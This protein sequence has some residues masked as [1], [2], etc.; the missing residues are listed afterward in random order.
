MSDCNKIYLDYAATTPVDDRVISKMM[1]YFNQKFGNSMG[2]CSFG[3][4]ANKALEDARTTMSKFINGKNG[5][6]IFT[7]SATESNNLALKGVF[8]ANQNQGK[9]EI[10]VS[11]V[12][13]DCV[14]NSAKYL[15]NKGYKLKYAP[16]DEFGIIKLDE[17]KKLITQKTLI[18]SIMH[19][20]NEVGSINPIAEIGKICRQNQALFHTD[21]AQ[22][23]GKENIDVEK[24]GIDMLTTSS[25][26][27]YGPKG[28]AF[29]WVRNGVSIEPIIHGGGQEFGLRS[30]TV[31]VPAIVGFSEATKIAYKEMKKEDIRLKK[32]RDKIFDFILKE[33]PNSKINGHVSKRLANNINASFKGIEGESIM[34][35]LDMNGLSVSTGSA[36]SSNKLEPSHVLVGMGLD[37]KYAQSAIRISL[38][39]FTKSGDVEYLLE[40]LKEVVQNLRKISPF[41]K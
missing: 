30:S 40:T 12:E 41:S 5:R 28:A 4:E 8:G 21:A 14:L 7:S 39:R 13:H 25:H 38:G 33:I 18:V 22:S 10:I 35:L 24:M 32:L 16:V 6:V 9:S 37:P 34:M 1:P 11:K 3:Q 23:F 36:C 15:E 2:I 27:A 29:L 20:N 26:K 19:A 17:L 31:N